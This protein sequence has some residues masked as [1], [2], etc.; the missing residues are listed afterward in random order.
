MYPNR[1]VC[2]AVPPCGHQDKRLGS[3]LCFGVLKAALV[4]VH[5][6]DSFAFLYKVWRSIRNWDPQSRHMLST[7]LH[8]A[9]DVVK[10]KQAS[11]GVAVHVRLGDGGSDNTGDGEVATTSVAGSYAVWAI[12]AGRHSAGV[13]RVACSE[14]AQ[15][16]VPI[17]AI[18]RLQVRRRVSGLCFFTV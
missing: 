17:P 11:P 16:K 14:M 6:V 9:K 12:T 13:L 15:T 10:A 3:D 1:K 8:A 7:Y 5:V 4:S 2:P 18:Q